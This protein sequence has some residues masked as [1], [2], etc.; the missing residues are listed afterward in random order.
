MITRSSPRSEILM[1]PAIPDGYLRCEPGLLIVLDDGQCPLRQLFLLAAG[2]TVIPAVPAPT[3]DLYVG[4]PLLLT[5]DFQGNARLVSPFS[6]Q[7]CV[8]A[9]SDGYALLHRFTTLFHY[10]KNHSK[11]SLLRQACGLGMALRGSIRFFS[12][13][14]NQRVDRPKRGRIRGTSAVEPKPQQQNQ[15]FATSLR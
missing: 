14:D 10:R 13:K 3:P 4:D 5:T 9:G 7:D 12:Q 15:Q 11:P 2:E 8:P 1:P 6:D